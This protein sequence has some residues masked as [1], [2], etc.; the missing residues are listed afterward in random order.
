MCVCA[1]MHV[2]AYVCAHV[3]VIVSSSTGLTAHAKRSF[4]CFVSYSIL[5]FYN[6]TQSA[7]KVS[8][9]SIINN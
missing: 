1:C 2:L 4:M 3:Y 7:W 6:S 8:V 5:G 9:K